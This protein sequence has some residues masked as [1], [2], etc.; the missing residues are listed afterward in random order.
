MNAP[1]F[2]FGTL[3]SG[4]ESASEAF[5]PLGAECAYVSEIEPYPCGVL[6]DRHGAGK[7]MRMPAPDEA[8]NEKARRARIAAIKTIDRFPRWANRLPNFGDLTQIDPEELPAVDLLVAGF[9]CQ[10]FSIAGLR[11]SLAGRRGNL[12]LYG[13]GLIHELVRLR[14]LRSVLLEQVPDILNTKDNAFGALLGGLV[15]HD[16]AIASPLKGG[17]WT[18]TGVAVG[19]LGTAAW[20]VEDAQYS[21][22]AQRRERLFLVA[23]FGDGPDPVEVLF[24]RQGL[25]RDPPARGQ[26]GE[27]VAGAVDA[28]AD[29]R[30]QSTGRAEDGQPGA[31]DGVPFGCD[32]GQDVGRPLV[33]AAAGNR[34][35]I[36]TETVVVGALQA[37]GKAAGSA[38]QQDAESGFLIP[39]THSLR[40]DGFDASEDGT[41]RGTPIVPVTYSIMPQNS[42]K[43]YKA[44]VVDV[45]QPLMASGPVGGDQGGDQGGDYVVQPVAFNLMPEHGLDAATVAVRT[46]IAA[47]LSARGEAA[48]NGRGV[49]IVGPAFA[50]Q[51]RAVSENPDAGPDGMGVKEGTAYTLEARSNAQAVAFSL[52]GRDGGAMPEI[53]E[54]G[55]SPALRS[56]E[57]GSTRPFVAFQT[58]GSNVGVEAELAGTIGSNADRASGSAPM[59]AFDETQIT[60]KANRSNPKPGDP[61][62]PLAAGA[63][64]Q[65]LASDMAVRRITVAEA[66]RL[67]G[68]EDFYTLIEWP[69]ANRKGDELAEQVAYLRSHGFSAEDAERLAQTPDGPQYKAIGNSKAVPLVRKIGA[70]YAAALA[71][72]L[73]AKAAA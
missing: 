11:Q 44:R 19:P 29:G 37:N 39:V 3:C 67:Q 43:D 16:A 23:S 46:D 51:E 2:T 53:E 66:N 71:R 9:P 17:R 1:A 27:G 21:H 34:S 49:H 62:H 14:R 32:Y 41:G 72:Y 52:R 33:A 15:G 73:T 24:E 45:A 60:S 57:G 35:D 69:T 54:G 18:N 31:A 5:L 47:A 30:R 40:A 64:P 58:R 38:T 59:V 36:E 56:A 26:A 25:S 8:E 48:K 4:I 28:G 7:P 10:D 20:R 13:V 61:C 55:V 70:A 68:F 63:R 22:V 42:G 65:T 6:A 12:T 50:I